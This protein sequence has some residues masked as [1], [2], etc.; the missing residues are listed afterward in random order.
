M[1]TR[2]LDDF[3]RAAAQLIPPGTLLGVERFTQNGANGPV[4]LYVTK[5]S[6]VG[7]TWTSTLLDVSSSP[8]DCSAF[9][10]GWTLLGVW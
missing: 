3:S 9:R 8:P 6:D 1:P 5:S 2:N 10:C 7:Q 4:N